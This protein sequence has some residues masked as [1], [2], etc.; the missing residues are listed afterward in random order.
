M[1]LFFSG[2]A[3]INYYCKICCILSAA[4]TETAATTAMSEVS[5]QVFNVF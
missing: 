5:R 1:L 4:I 2:F 3:N